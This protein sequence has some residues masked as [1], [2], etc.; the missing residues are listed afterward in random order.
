MNTPSPDYLAQLLAEEKALQFAAFDNTTAFA[1]GQVA[2]DL[3]ATA[4]L[5]VAIL[6]R[7]NGQRIFQA[8]LP[9]TGP[10]NDSW[11]DRKSR[12]VDRLGH[13]SY[14][15]RNLAASKGTTVEEMYQVDPAQHAAHGGAFPI[16]L[17][18]TGVIG[19]IA[20]SGLDQRDDHYFAVDAVRHFLE[21]SKQSG[22]ARP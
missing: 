11:L 2:L 22:E 3:A 7:R 19:T 5:P 9:G 14:Y 8:A 15:L 6:I 18:G 4:G 16:T 1:L 10:D 12:L 13:S 21:R 20:A 17:A